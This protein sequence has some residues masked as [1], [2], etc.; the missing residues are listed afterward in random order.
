MGFIILHFW[1]LLKL[2]HGWYG[3]FMGKK[4][5]KDGEGL[6]YA[7][8]GEWSTRTLKVSNDWSWLLNATC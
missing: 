7:Y 3:N 5:K 8:L 6:P 1:I 4:R 2:L